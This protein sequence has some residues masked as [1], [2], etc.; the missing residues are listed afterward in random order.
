M[1][2][3][4]REGLKWAAIW[5]G[6]GRPWLWTKTK[7]KGKKNEGEMRALHVFGALTSSSVPTPLVVLKK[8]EKKKLIQSSAPS[9]I[10]Y[11]EEGGKD[12]WKRL[13]Y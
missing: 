3:G 6:T 9:P 7:K 4:H 11:S 2:W 13:W 12:L 10:F 1:Y 8:K 5:C